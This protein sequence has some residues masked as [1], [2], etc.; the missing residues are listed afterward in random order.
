MRET[1]QA[2]YQIQKLDDLIRDN[3]GRLDQIPKDIADIQER[4]KESRSR[5]DEVNRQQEDLARQKKALEQEVEQTS[6]NIKKHQTQLLSVKTNKEYT[7]MLHEIEGEKKKTSDIEEQILTIM[8][9]LE[10]LGLQE[11]EEKNIF[12]LAEAQS[13]GKQQEMGKEA[14]GLSARVEEL[15]KNKQEAL[16]GLPKDILAMYDK[17]GKARNGTAVVAV[18]STTCGGCFGNLP[19]QLLNRIRDMDKIITCENCGRILIWQDP[20]QQ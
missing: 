11:T 4:L 12:K 6:S 9:S 1:L 5:L 18:K 15:R 16:A 14:A 20:K 2:I 17:I 7:T 8:E 3:Q 10:K 13:Q 19:T